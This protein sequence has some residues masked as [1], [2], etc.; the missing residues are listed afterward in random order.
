VGQK[1][2]NGLLWDGGPFEFERST[3]QDMDSSHFIDEFLDM[4]ERNLDHFSEFIDFLGDVDP[5]FNGIGAQYPED[6]V[7]FL[8]E[9]IDFTREGEKIYLIFYSTV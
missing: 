2:W 4:L 1:D 8:E 6:D 7:K 5:A 3:E 9:I